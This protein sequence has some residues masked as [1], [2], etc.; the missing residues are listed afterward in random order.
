M[1]DLSARI[2]SLCLKNPVTVASGTFGYGL[3][4]AEFYDPSILGAIFLKGLTLLPRAGNEIP[5]LVETPSGLI[6]SIGL[7]NIGIDEFAA[8]KWRELEDIDSAICVNISGTTVG[9]YE[10]LADRAS[11]VPIVRA[12]EVNV[13]CPNISHGGV[14]FGRTP[15]MVREITAK[16]AAA[17]RVP[18]LVKLT[19]NISDI[20]EI[21]AA[22]MEAGAAGVTLVNTFL[23]MAIDAEKRRPVLSN[24]MGGL[25]GPAIKPIALRMVWQVWRALRCPII[26]MGGIM[27]G[28]DA[29][30]FMLAGAS[31]ISVGTANFVN[32]AAGRDILSEIGGYCE[33]HGIN[34]VS[35]LI[36][37]AHHD[38]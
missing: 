35:E 32:P 2:G 11:R 27:T 15:A 5:R 20:V 18:V 9:E 23:A 38:K 13:S 4:F 28:T 10:E 16:C 3:E 24:V 33:R 21:A 1:A 29:I 36:G 26:G 12:I 6:N 34:R 31:A 22:A 14:E 8:R 25:S 37:A 30:E 19:P 7:Q 17:S